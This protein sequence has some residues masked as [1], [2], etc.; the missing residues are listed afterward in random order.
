MHQ[1]VANGNSGSEQN[2]AHGRTAADI[3]IYFY[4]T[5]VYTN[6][7]LSAEGGRLIVVKNNRNIPTSMQMY[8]KDPS[9]C[10]GV[11]VSLD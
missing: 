7:C 6:R 11:T 9:P 3:L 4:S 8:L 1:I 10:V 5:L 2:I